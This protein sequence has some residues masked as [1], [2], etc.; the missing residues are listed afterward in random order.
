MDQVNFFFVPHVLAIQVGQDV[1]F[2][3]S[4]P[5]NHAVHAKAAE[6][7][8]SFNIVTPPGGALRR[9]FLP[10]SRPIAISCPLHEGMAAWVYVFSH[11]HFAVTDG[12]GRFRLPAVPPGRYRLVVHHAEAPLQRR[13]DL[14]VGPGTAPLSIALGPPDRPASDTE[15]RIR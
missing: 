2:T 1:E 6:P 13:I 9:S 14:V 3:N 8:N 12:R 4:D 7:R 11:P 15:T 5:P 10:T